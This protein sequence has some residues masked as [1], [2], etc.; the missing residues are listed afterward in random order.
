MNKIWIVLAVLAA[1]VSLQNCNNSGQSDNRQIDSVQ[2]GT[3][4]LETTK[5]NFTETIYNFG[6]IKQGEIVKYSFSFK[7]DGEKP[8]LISSAQ[9]SC[10]CTVPNYPKEPIAPGE[11]G[12]I[13]V[14]FNSTGKLGMQNKSINITAN[15]DP[16]ITTLLLKGTVKKDSTQLTENPI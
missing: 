14:Q 12:V 7:N 5:I 3:G 6:T 2:L 13:D 4:K 1:A 10:G 9:A 16:A 15:T 8:L 11:T